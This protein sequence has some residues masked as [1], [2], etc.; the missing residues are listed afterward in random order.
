MARGNRVLV[1]LEC[2]DCRER[3][4]QTNKNKRTTPD[5]LE[6]NKYCRRCRKVTA[7]KETK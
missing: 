4:Y 1:Q 2:K 6:F 7:H 5:K 3:N